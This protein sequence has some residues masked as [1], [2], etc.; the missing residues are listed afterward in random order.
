[1]SSPSTALPD[2][3]RQEIDHFAAQTKE[4]RSGAIPDEQFR[5]FRLVH[6]IY[7]QRQE[8]VQ[9]IRIKVPGGQLSAAQARVLGQACR[10]FAPRQLGHVTTRQAVQLH[11]IRWRRSPPCGS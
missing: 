9:M 6:G 5:P 8:N 11:F 3:I 10:D 1:M 4:Y 7:G 2:L